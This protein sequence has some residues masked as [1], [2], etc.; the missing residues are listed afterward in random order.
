MRQNQL[1]LKSRLQAKVSPV[2][3][4]Y[5]SAASRFQETNPQ[6]RKRKSELKGG[7]G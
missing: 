4:S 7:L 1:Q 2:G 5:G 3:W 6:D